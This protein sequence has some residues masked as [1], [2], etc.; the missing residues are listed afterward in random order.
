RRRHTRSYGD[1]SS[2]VCSSDLVSA[3]ACCSSNRARSRLVRSSSILGWGAEAVGVARRSA[4]APRTKSIC[5]DAAHPTV[6]CAD[7]GAH[8]RSEERRVGKG[9]GWGGGGVQG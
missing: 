3:T 7:G 8:C 6:L 5:D 2:D 4:E 9:G 1:W